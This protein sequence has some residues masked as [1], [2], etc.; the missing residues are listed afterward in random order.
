MEVQKTGIFVHAQEKFTFA[1]LEHTLLFT[2]VILASHCV[3]YIHQNWP[4]V[5][6]ITSH[7]IRDIIGFDTFCRWLKLWYVWTCWVDEGNTNTSKKLKITIISSNLSINYP[8]ID[9]TL[10]NEVEGNSLV[11]FS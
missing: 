7:I 1:A 10:T 4:M 9:S 2:T 3:W 11:S 6:F 8:S 5:V